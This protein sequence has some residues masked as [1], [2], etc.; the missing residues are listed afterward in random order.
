[1]FSAALVIAYEVYTGPKSEPLLPSVL[2]M[3]MIVF[4]WLFSTRE[5]KL[6]EMYA[7]PTTF[8][9]NVCCRTSMSNE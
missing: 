1:M 4:L 3:L 8:V 7:G 9:W 5:T 6:W 2:E